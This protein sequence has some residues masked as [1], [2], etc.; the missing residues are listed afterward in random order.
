LGLIAGDC[1]SWHTA[2]SCIL[3]IFL[4]TFEAV[5]I[6]YC[7]MPES[8]RILSNSAATIPPLIGRLTWASRVQQAPL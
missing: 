5:K 3:K 2:E 4:K 8:M 6:S 7:S 1:H